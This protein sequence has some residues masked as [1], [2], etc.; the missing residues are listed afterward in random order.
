[1][2]PDW[3][4]APEWAKYL[5]MDKNGAWWWY[6]TEPHNTSNNWYPIGNVH[7]EMYTPSESEEWKK[8]LEK[9]PE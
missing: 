6:E 8:S 5:A 9:R 1:M 4:D 3:K 7:Y 2:K